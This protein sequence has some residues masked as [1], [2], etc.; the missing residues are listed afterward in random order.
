[1]N[2]LLA[3]QP[4]ATTVTRAAGP[5]V[6]LTL[7]SRTLLPPPRLKLL[8]LGEP[9]GPVVCLVPWL[10]PCTPDTEMFIVREE[11]REEPAK[12]HVSI[13]VSAAPVCL[14]TMTTKAKK[15]NSNL[16]PQHQSAS[17]EPVLL[18]HGGRHHWDVAVALR[19]LVAIATWRP[20]P[21]LDRT[22]LQTAGTT[23]RLHGILKVT[24][25]LSLCYLIRFKIMGPGVYFAQLV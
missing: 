8:L 18:G 5:W 19:C 1:M 20:A 10:A 3:A 14:L 23:I 16:R 4:R 25:L 22:R 15:K 7:F 24:F 11:L 21:L 13:A 17:L 6:W 9:S 2:V 12:W